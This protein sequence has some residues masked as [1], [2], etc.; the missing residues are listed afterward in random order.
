[1]NIIAAIH[2][3][4]EN[5]CVR[6]GRLIDRTPRA[7]FPVVAVGVCV[8]LSACGGAGPSALMDSH[9]ANATSCVDG[10]GA[11][12][13]HAD[14]ASF[15]G[16][17]AN[18]VGVSTYIGS[19]VSIDGIAKY[20]DASA[21]VSATTGFNNQPSVYNFYTGGHGQPADI[22]QTAQIA[23]GMIEKRAV[24]GGLSP[25]GSCGINVVGVPTTVIPYNP[26][27]VIFVEPH[28]YPRDPRFRKDDRY[29]DPNR[30]YNPVYPGF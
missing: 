3:A 17:A 2:S 7:M 29:Y 20:G 4:A 28:G 1:M 15:V 18:A 6:V 9:F 13:M 19:S 30:R 21:H 10:N 16:T 26:P 14:G 23:A 22:A 5:V 24:G 25:N 11:A 27:S 8:L 12:T